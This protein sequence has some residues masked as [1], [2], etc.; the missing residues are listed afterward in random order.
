MNRVLKNP[1][2][3]VLRDIKFS[4]IIFIIEKTVETKKRKSI[5][6]NYKSI[7]Q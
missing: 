6:G 4:S 3:L 5:K 1:F 7:E 2:F